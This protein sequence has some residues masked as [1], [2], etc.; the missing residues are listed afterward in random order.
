MSDNVV[1]H[2]AD[3]V[4]GTTMLMGDNGTYTYKEES[5][6]LGQRIEPVDPSPGYPTEYTE[7][8][9]IASQPEWN[10]A[11]MKEFSGGF[12]NMPVECQKKE[13]ELMNFS[14]AGALRSMEPENPQRISADHEPGHKGH[15]KGTPPTL[16]PSEN[17]T[18]EEVAQ[19]R[20]LAATG[21]FDNEGEDIVS[22][23][24][25]DIPGFVDTSEGG[26]T[27]QTKYT[28]KNRDIRNA[29]EDVDAILRQ[30][31]DCSEFFG[32]YAL[33]ALGELDK[34]LRKGIVGSSSDTK[35]GIKMES[36]GE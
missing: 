21:I 22:G 5:E 36:S 28:N 14:I 4:T 12:F 30:K 34:T 10:C 15:G 9:D 27:N 26:M 1:F 29:I 16:K 2:T 33:Q 24:A 18:P 35:T 20:E 13:A 19:R 11:I 23:G 17:L 8:T 7:I 31:N 6:P 3:P 32:A 25:P